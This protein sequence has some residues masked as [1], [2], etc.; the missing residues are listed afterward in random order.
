MRIRD[1][2]ELFA[3]LSILLVSA[4]PMGLW[5]S[6]VFQ[7]KRHSL[8][9]PL[10]WLERLLLNLTGI[11]PSEEQNWLRYAG[12][13]LS[14]SAISMLF[15]Y[16]VL[17]FQDILPLNPQHLPAVPPSLAW[18]TAISFT[19]NTNWQAYGGESTLSYLSQMVALTLH[20]FFSAAVG[21]CAAVAVIRG[22]AARPSRESAT[23]GNFWADF[24]RCNVYILLP[25]SLVLAVF[26]VSQGVIQNFSPYLD[27]HTLEGTHQLVAMGPAASQ[28]AIKIL[29]TNG[30]G[31]FNANAAHPFENPNPL[32]NFIQM[33]AIFLIPSGLVYLLGHWTGNRK[34]GWSVWATMALLFVCGALLAAHFEYR[35]NPMLAQAGAAVSH[36]ME[37]KE[38]RFGVFD[39]SLFAAVTTA[40]SCGAVNAMHDS[41]TPLGGLVP[42]FNI[43]LGEI[44][45]GGV[46]SGLYGMILYIVLTVFLAGLM[47]GRTPEYLGKRIEGR[48]VKFAMLALIV[49]AF[50]ILVFSAL[51][52]VTPTGTN[53]LANNGPHG[54][55]EILY[56][57]SSVAGNNGSAFAGLNAN[58]PF[59]NI[60]LGIVMFAGRFLMM[61]PVL[62]I[63]G[64]L[65][66][67]NT[68]PEGEA[69]FPVHGGMFITLLIGVI[70][71]VGALTFFPAL[72]LGPIAEHFEMLRGKTF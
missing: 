56:A 33:L 60:A 8:K 28:I 9:K 32:S 66:E 51:A 20:N 42:L 45:F 59:Y 10:G 54:L 53:S 14:L 38:V 24:I 72:S 11:N 37:G 3:F 4:K 1:A 12:S 26:L 64:S 57:F 62:A 39:S 21:I 35:G 58:T 49:M 55:A 44:V 48:E 52:V 41:F 16:L 19:T 7:D 27:V 13:I 36:N 68:H 30:G 29:G 50:S 31:F 23:L 43:H 69:T 15:S 18:N 34:H 63:A 65:A 2:A 61:I 5:M 67:K 40:A 22:I 17:R 25:L 47:V 6:S 46:G 71:I 70:I